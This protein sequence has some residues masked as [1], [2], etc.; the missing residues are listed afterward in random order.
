MKAVTSQLTEDGAKLFQEA[1][2]KLLGAVKQQVPQ[3]AGGAK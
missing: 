1:F 2:D 3:A